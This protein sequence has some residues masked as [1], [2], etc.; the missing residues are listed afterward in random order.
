MLCRRQSL[1]LFLQLVLVVIRRRRRDGARDGGGAPRDAGAEDG[2]G[3]EEEVELGVPHLEE[4]LGVELDGGRAREVVH[5]LDEAAVLAEHLE[6]EAPARE[7]VEDARVAAGNVHAAA[8]SAEVHVHAVV[9]L[10]RR[11]GGGV[12]AAAAAAVATEDDGVGLH[13]V[14]E[15]LTVQLREPHLLLRRCRRGGGAAGALGIPHADTKV[16]GIGPFG[17]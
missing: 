4:V 11:R 10:Q 5:A 15:A 9:G 3:R 16:W 12:L 14:L 2:A 13:V 8:E 17:D 6:R 1:S 7:V